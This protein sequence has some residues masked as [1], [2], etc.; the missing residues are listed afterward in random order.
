MDNLWHRVKNKGI[1]KW[2]KMERK[3]NIGVLNIWS[4]ITSAFKVLG[5]MLGWNL[6]NNE[7]IR[8]GMDL[9]VGGPKGFVLSLDLV[10][11]FHRNGRKML[12]HL[13]NPELQARNGLHILNW[14]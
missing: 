10:N 6:R 1:E 13:T 11:F 2:I 4:G 14:D 3:S 12:N 7:S 5:Q 8:V 9:I